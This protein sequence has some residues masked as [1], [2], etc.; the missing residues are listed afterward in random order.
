[1]TRDLFGFSPVQVSYPGRQAVDQRDRDAEYEQ[2][3][4]PKRGPAS[5]RGH[6]YHVNGRAYSREEILQMAGFHEASE[7]ATPGQVIAVLLRHGCVP[8][9]T[10]IVTFEDPARSGLPLFW[11]HGEIID[12][13]IARQPATGAR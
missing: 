2:L 4:P 5:E 11:K 6:W 12:M 10:A 8:A 7:A 9:V 3:E 13:R 1:M